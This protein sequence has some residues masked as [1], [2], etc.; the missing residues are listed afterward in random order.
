MAQADFYVDSNYAGGS[1]DGSIAHPYTTL[2]GIAAGNWTTL[3]NSS[4]AGDPATVWVKRGSI[5]DSICTPTAT[6]NVAS[7]IQLKPYGTGAPPQ[8]KNTAGIILNFGTSKCYFTFNQLHIGPWIGLA[9]RAVQASTGSNNIVLNDCYIDGEDD[10]SNASTY[11]ISAI[12]TTSGVILN[13]CTITRTYTAARTYAGAGCSIV[14]T[15]CDICGTYDPFYRTA[16]STLSIEN[17]RVAAWAGLNDITAAGTGGVA[18]VGSGNVI[19]GIN[20]NSTYN[21]KIA[22]FKR[23]PNSW[24]T[25]IGVDDAAWY[26]GLETQLQNR[27]AQYWPTDHLTLREVWGGAF[28][29][30]S[31][32]WDTI[33]TNWNKGFEYVSHGCSHLLPEASFEMLKL[34]YNGA[35]AYCA[36]EITDTHLITRIGPDIDNLSQDL[37]IDITSTSWL[38]NGFLGTTALASPVVNNGLIKFLNAGDASTV[39]YSCVAGNQVNCQYVA[40]QALAIINNPA[41]N[42]KSTQTTYSCDVQRFYESEMRT[43]WANM[44][45]ELNTNN[46]GGRAWVSPNIYVWPGTSGNT[47]S[48][49]PYVLESGKGYNFNFA[50]SALDGS[51]L[52]GLKAGIEITYLPSYSPALTGTLSETTLPAHVKGRLLA[53]ALTGRM[54]VFYTH[55]SGPLTAAQC[56]IVLD[57]IIDTKCPYTTL[58]A[59]RD[60]LLTQTITA[61]TDPAGTYVVTASDAEQTLDFRPIAGS[62]VINAGKLGVG[63]GFDINGNPRGQGGAYDIGCHEYNSSGAWL[64]F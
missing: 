31:A 62:P 2:A 20:G 55:I 11:C 23:F 10:L 12:S 41:V 34:T 1:N 51:S 25:N 38:S 8:L 16:A 18:I 64:G 42:L 63:T 13:G 14:F 35:A 7:P 9:A 53:A 5:C 52:K 36:V 57:A 45:L 24:I 22:N 54:L 6:G 60:Y 40:S 44:D 19:C 29:T 21:L 43:G 17:C 3:S 46:P 50:R 61:S 4:A 59:I 37:N 26:S 33:R 47:A 30:I 32:T 49:R 56:G 48:H 28:G 15:N 27:G 39:D 58:T